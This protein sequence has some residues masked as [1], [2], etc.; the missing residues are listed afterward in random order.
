MV[1]AKRRR[2]GDKTAQIARAR[3][4]GSPLISFVG[5]RVES[6]TS[7]SCGERQ[8]PRCRQPNQMCTVDRQLELPMRSKVFAAAEQ[9]FASAF[10]LTCFWCAGL[11]VCESRSSRVRFTGCIKRIDLIILSNCKSKI[12]A[13]LLFF[14]NRCFCHLEAR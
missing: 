4:I 9:K 3:E 6:K 1:S 7:E 13:S 14:C 2:A 10:Y 5:K 11:L 12:L 8:S